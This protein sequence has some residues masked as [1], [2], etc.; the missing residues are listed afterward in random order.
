MTQPWRQRRIAQSN[1]LTDRPGIQA[2]RIENILRF[3]SIL[4][5][6]EN[7]SGAE[8]GDDDHDGF[9][10]EFA[11]NPVS[12][13]QTQDPPDHAGGGKKREQAE[14]NIQ[15]KLPWCS[16]LLR[17]PIV[18]EGEVLVAHKA[19]DGTESTAEDL[20][21]GG[22][23]SDFGQAEKDAEIHEENGSTNHEVSWK[24]VLP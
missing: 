18:I 15:D 10:D 7:I 22:S 3:N 17:V 5:H 6:T 16:L 2:R 8:I 9:R 21:D 1:S 11:E 13:Q 24:A 23:K 12:I 20:C 19:Q 14:G 4:G